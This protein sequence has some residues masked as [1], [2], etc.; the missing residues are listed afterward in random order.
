ML[1][2][3]LEWDSSNFYSDD[4]FFSALLKLFVLCF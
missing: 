1:E 3:L 2:L 4:N